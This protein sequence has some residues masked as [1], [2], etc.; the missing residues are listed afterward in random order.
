MHIRSFHGAIRRFAVAVPI[1]IS[2]LLLGHVEDE[3]ALDTA[4]AYGNAI[5]AENALPGTT[6]WELTKPAR[7]GEIEGY[8]W[9]V[10]ALPGQTITVSVSTTSAHFSA[11]VY[12]LG[13]YQGTGARQVA[14]VATLAGHRYPVPA[15]DP[16]TG[17]IACSWPAAF[18]VTV[19]ASWTSGEYLVKVTTQE[20]DEAYI[21]FVVRSTQPATYL[22][23]HAV[24]T[25][26]AYNT[27]GGDSLYADTTHWWSG[28][29]T[30]A[31]AFAVSFDRPFATAD[32]AGNMLAWEDPMIRWLERQGDDVS[33]TT[34]VDIDQTPASLLGER[35][36]LI[37][38][39]D[40]YWSMGMRD[41]YEQAVNAGVDL[42]VFAANT[43]YWAVRFAPGPDGP[44]RVMICYKSVTLDPTSHLTSYVPTVRFL[45]SPISRP[46]STLLGEIY[47]GDFQVTP[48]HPGY[49]WVVSDAS[50]WVFNG[51]GVLNGQSIGDVVGYEYD[52]E[53]PAFPQPSGVQVIASSPVIAGS[54][55]AD[56]ANATIYTAQSG[57]RV[58]DAGTIE[59][60]WGLDDFVPPYLQDHQPI[61]ASRTVQRITANILENF[62][63]VA[64]IPL[65]TATPP[66]TSTPLATVPPTSTSTATA[67]RTPT[68]TLTSTPTPTS[69][70]TPTATLTPWPTLVPTRLPIRR[71]KSYRLT[72]R[73]ILHVNRSATLIVIV[74][75]SHGR[76]IRHVLISIFGNDAGIGR[77]LRG[78][79]NVHGTVEFRHVYPRRI[80]FLTIVATKK[81]YTD[82]HARWLVRA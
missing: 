51:T 55:A 79:T 24:N 23:V 50:S 68:A 18:A 58:F 43:G 13:W 11:A 61:P 47:G 42:G 32:G 22:F 49:P 12:R 76:A 52:R 2:V 81:G 77:V 27:W 63:S 41:A 38:G 40:E 35:G 34:D 74:R 14:S 37:A 10:S 46:E 78:A 31:R 82:A 9:Q 59:W 25:D 17:L 69:I 44:D 72:M 36:I 19:G 21:P 54:G 53:D 56:G 57:A 28:P 3:R 64:S 33:Y 73:G 29:G 8:A 4:Q 65:P 45:E 7:N 39:H 1:L 15:P 30:V 71:P 80:G 5:R 75:G 6:S 60:S 48:T 20:G 16:T 66:P 62:S 67:T 70:P 26:E